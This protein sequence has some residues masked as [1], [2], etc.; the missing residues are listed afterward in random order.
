MSQ[1]WK[2]KRLFSLE[3]T[4]RLVTNDDCLGI[5][6][7]GIST[8]GNDVGDT[9]ISDKNLS[10]VGTKSEATEEGINDLNIFT[11]SNTE[12]LCEEAL[13]LIGNVNDIFSLLLQLSKSDERYRMP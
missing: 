9:P 11:L 8:D 5:R 10:D 2:R 7:A 6:D 3:E 12:K 4:L 13:T 1:M